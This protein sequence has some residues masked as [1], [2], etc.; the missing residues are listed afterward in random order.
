MAALPSVRSPLAV[1]RLPLVV[2]LGVARRVERVLVSVEELAVGV[3][4]LDREMRGLRGDMREVV[5]GVERLREE[6]HTMRRGGDGIRG[7]TEDL[8][9]KMEGVAASLGHIDALTARVGRIGLRR[10]RGGPGPVA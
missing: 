8:D 4:S 1:A 5:D 3:R 10:P 2:G 7:A 6:V 9:A